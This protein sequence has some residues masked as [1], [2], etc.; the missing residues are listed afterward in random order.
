MSVGRK[1]GFVQLVT[2]H[3]D[4][5]RG[6]ALLRIADLRF[7]NGLDRVERPTPL[8]PGHDGKR[9]WWAGFKDETRRPDDSSAWVM[10]MC[11]DRAWR[12]L[13]IAIA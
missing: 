12:D 10:Q 8:D 11:A 6:P 13:I 7:A 4:R 2:E 9:E 5:W 3:G 1:I